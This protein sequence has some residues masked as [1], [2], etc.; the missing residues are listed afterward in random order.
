MLRRIAVGNHLL[1]GGDNMDLALAHY[2]AGRFAEK[3]VEARPLAIGRPVAFVPRGQG[4]AACR[5][6]AQKRTTFRSSAVAES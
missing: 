6:R 4:N 2:V 1:V 3:G 5:R